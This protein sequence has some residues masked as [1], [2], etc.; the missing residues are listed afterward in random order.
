MRGRSVF[1]EVIVRLHLNCTARGRCHY[2]NPPSGFSRQVLHM[3]RPRH[4]NIISFSL[5]SQQS[6]SRSKYDMRLNLIF[7]MDYL[8]YFWC[9]EAI[10]RLFNSSG[11]R[12]R[13][14][15]CT[16]TINCSDDFAGTIDSK[17]CPEVSSTVRHI[18]SSLSI[19]IVDF[20]S[21]S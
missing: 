14:H 17:D 15:H 11:A 6:S 2:L 13:P 19:I 5:L 1:D 3:C 20:N 18:V 8:R 10:A 16:H 12:T 9:Q 7:L 4:I 21:S